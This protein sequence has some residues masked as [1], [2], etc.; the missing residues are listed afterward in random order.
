MNG[1]KTIALA[2]EDEKGLD[3]NM[4]MHFGRCPAYVV[5]EV[6]GDK[7]GEARVVRN[8]Y[9]DAHQPGAVPQFIHGLG[10]NVILAGGMGPRA[11]DLFTNYGIKVATGVAGNV[12]RVLEAY[13]QGKVQGI[14]PCAHDHPESCGGEH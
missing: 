7:V 12:R 11:I 8:P 14:V 2:A 6:D 4:S 1:K 9:Y 3:G 10:A 5:V 13:L